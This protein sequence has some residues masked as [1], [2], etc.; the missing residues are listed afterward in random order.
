M[1]YIPQDNL[2]KEWEDF[3]NKYSG[4]LNNKT[5]SKL[6]TISIKDKSSNTR[7]LI[8]SIAKKKLHKHLLNDQKNLCIYC[9]Q[10]IANKNYKEK[11]HIEHIR[12]KSIRKDLRFEFTNL[13]V[14]CNGLNCSSEKDLI[15]KKFCGHYKDNEELNIN[16]I[17]DDEL[18]LHPFEIDDIESYFEYNIEGHI[19]P[20]KN[21]SP[22]DQKKATYMIDLIGLN[23][24]ELVNGR[25]ESYLSLI[26]IQERQGI[27]DVHILLDANNN[28]YLSFYPM[29][30]ALFGL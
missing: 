1:R 4:R 19:K 16:A 2:C 15:P 21:K 30:K 26:D 25:Q 28:T 17:F 5:W 29:L 10:E 18:F 9:L 20:N 7:I 13:A 11:S 3:T 14:S 8:G 12:P 24:P 6:T 23:N 27:E 22:N